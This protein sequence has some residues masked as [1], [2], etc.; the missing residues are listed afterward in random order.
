MPR[1]GNLLVYDLLDVADGL[2]RQ[3]GRMNL[4]KASMRRAVSSAYY[5]L[6]HAMCFVC[7]AVVVG[8]SRTGELEP[9]YRMLDHGQAKKRLTSA[10]AAQIDPR[11]ADIGAAFALLQEQRHLAD[12][13]PPSLPVSRDQTLILVAR[14]REA[15]T[16]LESLNDD[17][18]RRLAV[19]LITKTRLA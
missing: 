13:S 1:L 11:V 5:A 19:L 4:R 8:W 12:Y 9:V 14:A 18:R 2:V 16:A 6:F 7:A 17:Q 3:T 15:V 10:E